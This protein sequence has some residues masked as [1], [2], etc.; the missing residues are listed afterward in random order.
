MFVDLRLDDLSIK[1]VQGQLPMSREFVLQANAVTAASFGQK[2]P[3]L[4]TFEHFGESN[5]GHF[6]FD[7]KNRLIGYT[8]NEIYAAQTSGGEIKVNYFSSAF[9]LREV[10]RKICLYKML[11]S[12][13]LD[14]T[15]QVVMVRTQNPL[16]ITYFTRICEMA[17][18]ELFTPDK[19]L[20]TDLDEIVFEKFRRHGLRHDGVYGRCLTGTPVEPKTDFT[21]RLF[22]DLKPQNGDAIVLIGKK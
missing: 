3:L 20:P 7:G 1:R 12:L 4:E 5:L 21:K 16:V 10:R 19:R 8:L 13:R 11:S 17:R 18:L 2:V 22:A 9:V 14:Y 15:E 6:V